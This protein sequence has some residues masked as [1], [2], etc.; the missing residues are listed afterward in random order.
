MTSKNLLINGLAYNGIESITAETVD[1][2]SVEYIENVLQEKT[3]TP[4]SVAQEIVADNG[5]NGLSKVA[6]NG[7]ANLVA[8]NIVEG[9]SIFGVTGTHSCAASV[10]ETCTVT[11]SSQRNGSANERIVFITYTAVENG[12]ITAKAIC[13]AGALF[14]TQT[15]ENVLC[16]ST[17]TVGLSGD[18]S[19]W[20]NT[21]NECVN[22]Y[23]DISYN[24]AYPICVFTA[25][26]EQDAIGTVIFN[27]T[28]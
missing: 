26:S 14:Q 23:F 20:E 4:S 3:V 10:A 24:S 1:G 17:V 28:D 19:F 2:D 22:E 8:T 18:K 13:M 7:D 5:Y 15:L 9:V 21:F 11:I 27:Y 6:V 25:P 16:S 12:A